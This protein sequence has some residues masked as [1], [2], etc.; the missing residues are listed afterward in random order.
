MSYDW[1]KIYRET[2]SQ[3]L[4]R[5]YKGQTTK[6]G[7][8]ILFA[9]KELDRRGFD[10][11]N[12]EM[13]IKN[14]QL[15]NALEDEKLEE[16]SRIEMNNSYVSFKGFILL[17]LGTTTL[18]YGVNWF[19]NQPLESFIESLPFVVILTIVYVLINNMIYNYYQKK[20]KKRQQKIA[21]LKQILRLHNNEQDNKI[22]RKDLKVIENEALSARTFFLTYFIIIAII[23]ISIAVYKYLQ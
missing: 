17:L 6:T 10:F 18:V 13:N 12:M 15:I 2:S 21:E 5:I 20:Y 19:D 3:E 23:V 9:K 22:F 11:N 4:Y 14:W 8:A 1:E 7:E 16:I